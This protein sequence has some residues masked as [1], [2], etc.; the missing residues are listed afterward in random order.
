MATLSTCDVSFPP[1]VLRRSLHKQPQALPPLPSSRNR[2]RPQHARLIP[3]PVPVMGPRCG[4]TGICRAALGMVEGLLVCH[5]D[6]DSHYAVAVASP[7]TGAPLGAGPPGELGS[8]AV[9]IS[10]PSSVTSSVCS[11]FSLA[12]DLRYLT[13]DVPN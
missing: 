13:S 11:V 6:T 5:T 10:T 3:P 4:S 8:L 2:P 9:K 1:S 12:S 7:F